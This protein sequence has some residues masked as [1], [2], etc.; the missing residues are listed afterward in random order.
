[1]SRSKPNCMT[2]RVHPIVLTEV[3][4]A[5]FAIWV[6]WRSRGLATVAAISCALA[7]GS[8]ASI[9]MVGKSTSGSG[10]TGSLK[11]ATA[12]AAAKP[13]V[14]SVVATGRKMKNDKGTVMP[15]I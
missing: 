6:R 1:M 14:N 9:E 2:M 13:K 11:N 8:F 5:T 12:P 10:E 15:G 4:S 7:P 3:I